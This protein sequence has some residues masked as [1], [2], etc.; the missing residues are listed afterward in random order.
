MAVEIQIKTL[1]TELSVEDAVEAA[2]GDDLDWIT[3]KLRRGVSVLVE[4][5]KQ[6]VNFLYAAVR[7]RLRDP[8]QGRPLRCRFV[9]GQP[10]RPEGQD[11]AQQQQQLPS[12][13][14]QLMIREITDLVRSAE[15]GTVI[16]IPHVDLLTTTT[17][18][19]LSMEAKE[20]I[21]LVY[22][23]PEVLLLGFKDP[24]FELPKTVESVFTA[25][26]SI[27]GIDRARLTRVILQREARKL[28]VETFDPFSLYKYVS[29]LNVVRLRQVL[30]QF[31]D[32]MDYDPRNPEARARI[33]RDIRELTRG[34]ELEIPKI[35]LERDIG[36]Y[37]GVKERINK[38]I[39]EL[40]TRCDAL[41]GEQQVKAVEELIPR[42]IIFE[43][44][45]GTGKTYFAKAI[46][47]AID[48][49][50]IV[51]SGP[52]LKSKWV[53]ES[54]AN[55]RNIFTRARRSAPSIIIF[56]ELDSF[57]HRRGSYS[58]SG[59]EHS[60]VNQLLTEMD[61]FRKEELVFVV[62]TTNFVESLDDALLRPGRFELKIRIP[63]PRERDR[64]AILE[65]YKQKF[66]LAL[67]DPVFE[68]TV[69]KTSGYVNAE[70]RTRFSGDHLYALCRGLARESIRRGEGHVITS[71]DVD[72]VI[73][74][75]FELSKPTEAEEKVIATHECGHALVGALLPHAA[76]P[77]KVTIDGEEELSAFYTSFDR[78]AMGIITTTARAEADVAVAFGGRVAEE[79]CYGEISA[80]DMSDLHQA[81][82]LARVMVEAW[83]MGHSQ[84]FCYEESQE[85][86]RRRRLSE[87]REE[88]VDHEVD[89]ILNGQ[90]ERARQ[91]LAEHRETLQAMS[92]L[93]VEKK[94]LER[95][96]LK[97]FFQARGYEIDW[98][99]NKL[100]VEDAGSK[101]QPS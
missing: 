3:D 29:G 87:H 81:T 52:E 89:T 46:A 13:L 90:R 34:S 42:G 95:K 24:E 88:Q 71:E 86:F 12:S 49:T 23:N 84:E 77:E 30:E 98:R 64:R 6:V 94:V 38:D 32:R 9:S 11:S 75:A 78:D 67:P 26:R 31:G 85:G 55:L 60:M 28:G 65:I 59:V 100:K 37:K 68:Y 39:L 19:G 58:G 2:Y 45:P 40:L 72:A 73:G 16:V 41:E 61:G 4:C 92:A 5:D 47:T 25:R 66:Q 56:D 27:L 35:D 20:V 83:G 33:F 18:S 99:E 62:G 8:E 63:Y 57:A 17:R 44:P 80:G 91:L 76:R 93:L 79:L 69:R 48:A 14:M 82:R 54:E 1:P 36:G 96:D 101:E 51:V 22:E 43:G 70:R 97:D 15:P 10:R 7:G 53:G 50:A 74:D 21:A